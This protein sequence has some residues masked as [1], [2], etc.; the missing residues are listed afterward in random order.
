MSEKRKAQ[1]EA[2]KA[3]KLDK[4][5]Q[6]LEKKELKKTKRGKD[7]NDNPE[8]LEDV[9]W[10]AEGFCG[11]N[12][13]SQMYWHIDTEGTLYITGSGYM[14]DFIDDP[15]FSRPWGEYANE[16]K[17]VYIEAGVKYIGKF[18]FHGLYNL[19]G[20]GVEPGSKYLCAVEGVL[21]NR[22]ITELIRYPQC[23]DAEFAV[24][25]TITRID[26]YAFA[27]CPCLVR[28]ILNDNV[29]YLGD[30]AFSY[31]PNLKYIDGGL[32]IQEIPE[33]CFEGCSSFVEFRIP[34]NVV[35]V[36]DFAFIN[37]PELQTVIFD[38]N[39]REIGIGIAD[40]CP[41]FEGFTI[42]EEN[43]YFKSEDGVLFNK[44][45]SML[46]KYPAIK[47]ENYY[48]VPR[49]VRDIAESSFAGNNA[50]T[51]VIFPNE[52]KTIGRYAFVGCSDLHVGELPPKLVYAGEFM[53][54]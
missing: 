43:P 8:E 32:G 22:D 14:T 9:N 50:L 6:K 52:L 26:D 36:R 4:K 24:P 16:I 23:C 18:A 13:S 53:F 33:F 17:T 42:E 35:Y 25:D 10:I 3:R 28:V 11:E 47:S 54:G 20:F 37:C 34:A 39:V 48:I 44:N 19:I 5:S 12:E 2:K 45:G 41:N 1:K 21:Y 51:S 46:I 15:H 7:K 49:K 30:H 27:D 38:R 31:C 29:I 40:L